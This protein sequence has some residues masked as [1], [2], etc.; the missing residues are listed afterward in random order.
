[1]LFFQF[2]FTVDK[3]LCTFN[4]NH[5]TGVF[6]HEVFHPSTD[7]TGGK[8]CTDIFL[9]SGLAHLH[10]LGKVENLKDILV[11][12]KTDCTQER[13]DRQ[14]LLT[15][16]VRVHHIV[17]VG[18]EL[19]P[20]TLERDDTGRVELLTVGMVARPEEHAGRAVELGH[21]NTFGSV[22]DKRT[23]RRHVGNHTQID[24]LDDILE[25][26]VFAVGAEQFQLRLERDTVCQP[27]V[28]TLFYA[29]TRRID[30]I[31]KKFEHEIIACVS[32][33]EIL[34]KN[35][36]KTLIHTIFRIGFQLEEILERFELDIQEIDVLGRLG[37][38]K[39]YLF[40]S[41]C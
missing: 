35:L 26:F 22:D 37:R 4:R 32:N 5:F 19:H 28:Q 24:F 41:L 10:F 6:I 20:G 12:F 17:D 21:D 38:C 16:D 15:V 14:F 39:I 9:Q 27:S 30:K 31:I 8:A 34:C 25:V 29:V 1:M 23:A 13:G 7:Y 36:V 11:C 40:D 3:D 2:R 18:S 33:W